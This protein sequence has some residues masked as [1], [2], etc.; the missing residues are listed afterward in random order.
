[1]GHARG[2]KRRR[3]AAKHAAENM[4][5]GGNGRDE[6]HAYMA[7]GED[8]KKRARR[9]SGLV[10]EDGGSGSGGSGGGGSEGKLQVEAFAGRDGV[11]DGDSYEE[12]RRLSNDE[13]RHEE[14]TES[15]ERDALASKAKR[16][17]RT[18]RPDRL[19]DKPNAPDESASRGELVNGETEERRL[20]DVN[21]PASNGNFSPM[22]IGAGADEDVGLAPQKDASG[23]EGAPTDVGHRRRGTAQSSLLA[24]SSQQPGEDGVISPLEHNEEEREE[25]P[26]A[27]ENAEGSDGAARPTATK[28]SGASSWSNRRHGEVT[29]PFSEDEREAVYRTIQNVLRQHAIT[30]TD[31]N[32]AKQVNFSRG[33][34]D[35]I[36][37]FWVQVTEGVPGR[38]LLAVYRHCRR[39]WSTA[40]KFGPWTDEEDRLL[41][42]LVVSKGRRW[43]DISTELGR[44]EGACKDRWRDHVQ[45]GDKRRTG[46]LSFEEAEKLKTL[47]LKAIGEKPLEQVNLSDLP[48]TQIS[49]QMSNRSG[50]QCA[51]AGKVIL[52]EM[53]GDR[54]DIDAVKRMR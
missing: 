42:E 5:E 31:E 3:K 52:R 51:A 35:G 1:M 45:L 24:G 27:R 34:K 15:K 38:G 53:M 19:K 17:R 21:S 50:V 7:R 16:K 20:N 23:N 13:R 12:V 47:A 40:V 36:D 18:K 33:A 4:K 29:G 46:P 49:K 44:Y 41:R 37:N 25:A 14:G 10:V 8:R 43:K 30:P 6:R 28:L 26:E 48:W 54:R 22:P 9:K 2:S 11:G 32:I 39:R